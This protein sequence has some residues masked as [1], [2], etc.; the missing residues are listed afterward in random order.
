MMDV[1]SSVNISNWR[2][3]GFDLIANYILFGL[4]C[5]C[6]CYYSLFG[7][8]GICQICKYCKIRFPN[9]FEIKGDLIFFILLKNKNQSKLMI[10][11]NLLKG[12]IGILPIINRNDKCKSHNTIEEIVSLLVF[13]GFCQPGSHVAFFLLTCLL[14]TNNFFKKL[15]N[16][17][18][19]SVI[20]LF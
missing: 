16:F 5:C 18:A 17:V 1:I 20:L 13:I 2:F 8:I 12:K 9:P 3:L 11:N 6:C 15:K 7:R 14:I 4:L 19:G 10:N